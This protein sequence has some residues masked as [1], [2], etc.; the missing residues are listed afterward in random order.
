MPVLLAVNVDV[1]LGFLWR[2]SFLRGR[3]GLLF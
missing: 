2:F 1:D 3:D